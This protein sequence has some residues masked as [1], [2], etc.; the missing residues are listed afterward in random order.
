MT[1]ATISL[2]VL[3][4]DSSGG[5]DHYP[6]LSSL[7]VVACSER[8]MAYATISVRFMHFITGSANKES[9]EGCH[10]RRFCIYL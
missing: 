5:A 3:C 6:C 2:F 4:E 1:V 10:G 7:Q 9:W 8:D